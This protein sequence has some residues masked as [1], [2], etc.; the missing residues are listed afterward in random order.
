ML[1]CDFNKVAKSHFG[2]DGCSSVNLPY[3]FR[4]PFYKNTSGGLLLNLLSLSQP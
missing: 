1:K 4:T 2:M 3:I